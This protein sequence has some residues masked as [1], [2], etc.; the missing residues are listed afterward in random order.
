MRIRNSLVL[1]FF[2]LSLF[3]CV[4][5]F[6]ADNS[7]MGVITSFIYSER[8]SSC[9]NSITNNDLAIVIIVD[10]LLSLFCLWS[11][12]LIIPKIKK[13]VADKYLWFFV[14]INICWG[15]SLLI[16]NFFWKFFDFVVSL[17]PDLKSVVTDNFILV[18]L[19]V[20]LI[21]YVWVIAR[22]FGLGL[23]GA[24]SSA[25]FSHI[26]YFSIIWVSLLVIPK[27]NKFYILAK[28][29]FGVRVV[30]RSYVCDVNK[31]ISG[32]SGIELIRLRLFHL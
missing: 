2:I 14:F 5:S 10:A 21:L 15:I 3:L 9:E 18:V 4:F 31:A 17:R 16:F 25:I 32:K 22:V 28:E 20:S 11:T 26:L 19:A 12:L 27:D 23:K 29:N 13:F 6:A 24:I 8:N 30:L 1:L 7:G